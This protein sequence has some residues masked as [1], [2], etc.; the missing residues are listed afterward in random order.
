ME[1]NKENKDKKCN[2]VL[3]VSSIRE[4][5]SNKAYTNH[6]L[7]DEVAIAYIKVNKARLSQFKKYPENIDELLVDKKPV[8][9][10]QS[11]KVA[12]K[13]VESKK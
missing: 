8:K 13:K 5:N 1:S 4:F 9:K 12:S 11:K 7:T 2:F 10:Q 3:S 6:T